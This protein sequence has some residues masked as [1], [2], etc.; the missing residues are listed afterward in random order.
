MELELIHCSY[1]NNHT[2]KLGF[3]FEFSLQNKKSTFS[4]HTAVCQT[5][6]QVL[7]LCA[8]RED[9]VPPEHIQIA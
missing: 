4:S 6:D 2:E 3:L 9:T 7:V 5:L 1:G 8:S